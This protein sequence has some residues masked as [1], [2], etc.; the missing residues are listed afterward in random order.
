[1]LYQIFELTNPYCSSLHSYK[2]YH[3]ECGSVLSIPSKV[4][5]R[6]T[7][8]CG[9]KY[10]GLFRRHAEQPRTVIVLGYQC[11]HTSVYIRNRVIF[12]LQ[13]KMGTTSVLIAILSVIII[14]MG[15]QTV[16]DSS[17]M[18]N[19]IECRQKLF[20][21]IIVQRDEMGRKCRGWVAMWG[22][23]GRCKSYVVRK[24]N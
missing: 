14:S 24:L 17:E 2:L 21:K 1:M 8:L 10:Q 12:G 22:C 23:E 6:L 19:T 3:S 16:A 7:H 4:I 18:G 13:L 11:L 5:V 9:E 20:H 15:Y